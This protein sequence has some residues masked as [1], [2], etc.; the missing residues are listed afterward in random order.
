MDIMNSD[1]RLEIIQTGT[2]NSDSK[3]CNKIAS[4]N[5]ELNIYQEQ[6][7]QKMLDLE[8][9]KIN[10][11]EY[12]QLNT[13]IGVL[14]DCV[15]SGKTYDICG[16]L[17]S[18]PNLDDNKPIHYNYAQRLIS[19][20]KNVNQDDYY[21]NNLIIVPHSLVKQWCSV[22]NLTQLK[23]EIISKTK[24]LENWTTEK[25]THGGCTLLSSTFFQ[26]FMNFYNHIRWSRVIIDECDTIN[27]SSSF[28]PTANFYWFVTSSLENL[29]FCCGTYIHTSH[30][31][32]QPFIRKFIDGIRKRS[33][34]REI[35]KGLERS[36][37][38]QLLESITLKHKDSYI[39]NILN[40][41][42]IKHTYIECLEPFYMK[43]LNGIVT[44]E[45][46]KLLNSGNVDSA[47]Y[48]LGAE[49]DSEDNILQV[50]TKHLEVKLQNTKTRLEFLN[51]ILVERSADI[52]QH[53][54]RIE[55][56]ENEIKNIY[57]QIED[58]KNRIIN[59]KD[60]PICF[61]QYDGPI[62]MKCCN[63]KFCIKCITKSIETSSS[64]PMCRSKITNDSMI[65]IR[66]TPLKVEEKKKLLSKIQVIQKLLN[67]NKNGKF[68]IFSNN[69][70]G[71]MQINELLINNGISSS[72]ISGS[73]AHIN[74]VV[75]A[76]KTGYLN[77]LL[78]N[79]EYHG[80]G[81]NLE[82]TTD[83]IF[84]HRMSSDME[85]QVI[86]RAQR[87]GRKNSLKVHYL[88]YENEMS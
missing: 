39:K 34:I 18:R 35:F 51:N 16:L 60:C 56:T 54:K 17:C 10:L 81:L 78:L 49:V 86:G 44:R 64:C 69:D 59:S 8:I 71:L 12:T 4:F 40:L 68:L 1:E 72:Q 80:S 61:E 33:F 87:L 46:I 37:C 58:L 42:A 6:T 25:A 21:A 31:A 2:I 28:Q 32:H 88:C 47:I 66:N 67:E 36:E 15:G 24:E 11:D 13:K 52:E 77:V 14:A 65:A 27:I 48:K 57:S 50:V 26:R 30:N 79:A 85:K 53:N 55:N 9:N 3:R 5:A 62:M 41:P 45:V 70:I 82:N 84:Y 83:L 7:V 22:L 73:S 74:K 43:V 75:N 20:S 38:T 29:Y 76:Y 19:I 63:N 23:Y